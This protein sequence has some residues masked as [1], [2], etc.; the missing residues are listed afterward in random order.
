MDSGECDDQARAERDRQQGP[1]CTATWGV[2]PV[3]CRTAAQVGADEARQAPQVGED[4]HGHHGDP[5]DEAGFVQQEHW[6]VIR[7]THGS[8][9]GA[10]GRSHGW[11]DRERRDE[12]G[13]LGDTRRM[14]HVPGVGP[15]WACDAGTLERA[16][17]SGPAFSPGVTAQGGDA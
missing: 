9:G 6:A 10:S 7:L 11:E 5:A 1:A 14:Y 13:F 2:S 12:V 8:S 15:R 17:S 3:A 16:G 4:V